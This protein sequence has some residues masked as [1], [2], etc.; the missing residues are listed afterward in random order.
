M[1]LK[2][3]PSMQKYAFFITTSHFIPKMLDVVQSKKN[4]KK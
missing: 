1:R 4:P 2:E 3:K